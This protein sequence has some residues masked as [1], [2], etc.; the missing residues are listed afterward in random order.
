[1]R[2]FQGWYNPTIKDFEEDILHTIEEIED[3]DLPN[4]L[5]LLHNK[6]GIQ[7]N[8]SLFFSANFPLLKLK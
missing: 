1:M 6:S 4:F 7:V 2:I 5:K 8:F 3:N